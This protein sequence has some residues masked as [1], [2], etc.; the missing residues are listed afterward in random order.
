MLT[1]PDHPQQDKDDIDIDLDFDLSE[2]E[3]EANQEPTFNEKALIQ[4]LNSDQEAA[5]QSFMNFMLS[6]TTHYHLTGGAG[7]G[8]TFTLKHILTHGFEEYKTG[9]ALLGIKPTIH[10]IVFTATTNKAAEVLG[11]SLGREVSTIHSFMGL[12]VKEDFKTGESKISITKNTKVV[13]NH[14]III[15]EASMIDKHLFE[16]L[17]A[18][19]HKCKF[20]YVGDHCQMAPVFEKLSRIYE[21]KQ[22]F[23]N[24][25]I[26]MRNAGQPALM[27]LCAQLRQTVETGV[28]HPI[29]EVPGVIDYVSGPTMKHLI[30]TTFQN[31]NPHSRVLCFRNQQVKDF[32]TYI[33]QLRGLPEYFTE[34]EILVCASAYQKSMDRLSVEQQVR[35]HK[36]PFIEREKEVQ[37]IKFMVYELTL[38][39]GRME[40]LDVEV[41]ADPDHFNSLVR[42]FANNNNWTGYFHLKQN[43]PDLRQS[44]ACTVYKAQ[45][46]TYESVFVDLE[47]ISRC[48]HADQVARMLYVA[49]SRPK[50]QLY[51]YGRLKPAY[52]G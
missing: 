46:S 24:L 27:D 33:R 12:K 49:C 6:D 43:Y 2:V 48:T 29:K 47:D 20:L 34:D 23:S 7:T 41:P 51:L 39:L 22:F 11:Q 3:A 13:S 31:Q 37:G 35:V 5:V 36:N 28:F 44:D 8:K 14:L 40:Y 52:A 9:C 25:S 16:L 4:N 18:Y 19:T 26:P 15:D 38:D 10:N 21:H 42:Y 17:S 32:N 30:D 1:E 45:G 50:N